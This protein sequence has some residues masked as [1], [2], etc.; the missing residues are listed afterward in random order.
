MFEE[1]A[2]DAVQMLILLF[3]TILAMLIISGALWV[4]SSKK[5]R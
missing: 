2:S 5:S 4:Y 1:I 3:W